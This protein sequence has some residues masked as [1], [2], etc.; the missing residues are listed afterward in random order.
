MGL[1]R[2]F[3]GAN[4]SPLGNLLGRHSQ[5]VRILL[6]HLL[7]PPVRINLVPTLQKVSLFLYHHPPLPDFGRSVGVARVLEEPHF[8][9]DHL[10]VL[11]TGVVLF[12]Y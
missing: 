7:R 3:L 2:V 9:V 10:C 6:R 8:V 12:R 4:P 5:E 1:G 11:A